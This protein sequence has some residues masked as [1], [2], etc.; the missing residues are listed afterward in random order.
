M[1][2]V[3]TIYPGFSK[4]VI[5]CIYRIYVRYTYGHARTFYL[6][7]IAYIVHTDPYV[8][9]TSMSVNQNHAQSDFGYSWENLSEPNPNVLL[10]YRVRT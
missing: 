10:W 8:Q 6:R 1:E 2:F 5:N 3:I 4:N 7:T 9:K